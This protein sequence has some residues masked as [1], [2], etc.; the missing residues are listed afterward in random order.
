M[1]GSP[2]GRSGTL[3][4][5][6]GSGTTTLAAANVGLVGGA[7]MIGDGG[8]LMASA[9]PVSVADVTVTGGSSG[10]IIVAGG[11]WTRLGNRGHSRACFPLSTGSPPHDFTAASRTNFLAPFP[12]F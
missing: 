8:I 10:G 3:R 12:A 5:Q 6:G 2:L 1:R 7:L 11:S 4:I 9:S